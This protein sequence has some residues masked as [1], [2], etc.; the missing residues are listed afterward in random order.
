MTIYLGADHGGFELKEKLKAYLAQAKY[1]MEDCGAQSLVPDDDFPVYANAVSEKVKS[2]AMSFGI[3]I[4]RS[5]GGM[6]IAAN[7]HTGIRAVECMSVEQAEHA[8]T[9]NNA[10]VLTLAAQWT[11]EGDAQHIVD[12]FLR[13]EFHHEERFV[14][15][16]G[17]VG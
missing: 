9:N 10:N 1:S 15:R 16:V 4:C 2:D 12:A 17:M 13:T 6:T 3:L 8:R 14:R 5:G 7:R 11:S